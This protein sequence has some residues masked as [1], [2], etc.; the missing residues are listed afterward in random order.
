MKIRS[1]RSWKVCVPTGLVHTFSSFPLDFVFFQKL[2]SL[3]RFFTVV[4]LSVWCHGCCREAGD[5]SAR[6]ESR[7]SAVKNARVRDTEPVHFASDEMDALL[8]IDPELAL[9]RLEFAMEFHYGK[10]VLLAWLLS[11]IPEVRERSIEYLL[12]GEEDTSD[13]YKD[14]VQRI[15]AR[16]ELMLVEIDEAARQRAE[17]RNDNESPP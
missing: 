13:Y 12:K 7:D 2:G 1:K 14:V 5:S 17:D 3:G 10:E 15:S 16:K 11:E 4:G 8:S 6:I 9:P